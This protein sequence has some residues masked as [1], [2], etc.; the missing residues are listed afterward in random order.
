ML[1]SGCL[2]VRVCAVCPPP[3]PPLPASTPTVVS[4]P[5]YSHTC[6]PHLDFVGISVGSRG[7]EWC[8]DAIRT[9]G[10]S[11]PTAAPY[12]PSAPYPSRYDPPPPRRDDRDR[13]EPPRRDDRYEPPRRDDRYDPPRRDDRGYDRDSRRDDRG[14][15]RGSDRDYR[16]DDRGSDRRDDRDR[17]RDRDYRDRDR[18]YRR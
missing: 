15:D 10:L 2:A 4:A 8:S 1:V 18:D 17:D 3:P 9:D 5:L 6:A 13:Y 16:R 7:R 11:F 14:Y 12:R